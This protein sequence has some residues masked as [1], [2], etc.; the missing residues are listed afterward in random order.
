[1]PKGISLHIGV[2]TVD[3]TQY[4]DEFGQPWDGALPSCENDATAMQSIADK[5]GFQST[6]LQTQDATSRNVFKHVKQAFQTLQAGDIFFLSFS[7]HGGQ[8]WDSSND[9]PVNERASLHLDAEGAKDE[10]MVL[11]DREMLDDELN[12][13]FSHFQAGVRVLVLSDS[14][15]SGTMTKDPD[16][17]EDEFPAIKGRSIEASTETVKRNQSVY[18]EAWG[19]QEFRGARTRL[20]CSVLLLSGCLDDQQSY[21]GNPYSEFTRSLLQTWNNGSFNGSYQ[22]LHRQV[23][24]GISPQYPQTPNYFTDGKTNEAFEQQKPFTI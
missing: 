20:R 3:P 8:Q 4:F 15:H 18:E 24:A 9:E 17:I 12:Q 5:Q 11:Y 16:Q 7:G 10:T 22:D 13:L 2:N 1:M 23:V 19:K 14:C 6:L 21:A